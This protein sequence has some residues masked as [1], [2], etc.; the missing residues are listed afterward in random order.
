[1]VFTR[2]YGKTVLI[3]MLL[4]LWQLAGAFQYGVCMFSLCQLGFPQFR[5]LD[6]LETLNYLW[7]CK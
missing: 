7:V 6:E 5:R 3:I 2:L 4:L 1:M